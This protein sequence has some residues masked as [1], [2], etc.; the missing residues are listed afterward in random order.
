M[1]DVT[2]VVGTAAVVALGR[3]RATWSL[4]VAAALVSIMGNGVHAWISQG[5]RNAVGVILTPPVFLLW[6]THRIV[7]LGRRPFW[8]DLG[9]GIRTL[10]SSVCRRL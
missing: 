1:I 3:D 8:S 6:T 5:P 2:I 7:E 10:R 9:S 4:L